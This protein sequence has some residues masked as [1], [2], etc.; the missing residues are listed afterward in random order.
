MFDPLLALATTLIAYASSYTALDL[1]ASHPR[2][3]FP[4]LLWLPAALLLAMG[5]L[6]AHFGILVALGFSVTDVSVVPLL[7]TGLVAL[8]GAAI[9]LAATTKPSLRSALVGGIWFG[10]LSVLMHYAHRLGVPIPAV[11]TRRL[12]LWALLSWLLSASGLFLAASALRAR[13]IRRSVRIGFAAAALAAS[14]VGVV[15]VEAM[16][17]PL[18]AMGGQPAV[19]SQNVLDQL[20]Q[21]IAFC[22]AVLLFTAALAERLQGRFAAR[23]ALTMVQHA[24]ELVF[25]V[26]ADG[27]I[28]QSSPSVEE[29]LGHSAEA[30]RGKLLRT[31]LPPGEEDALPAHPRGAREPSLPFQYRGEMLHRDGSVHCVEGVGIDLLRDPDVGGVVLNLVDVTAQR[32]AETEMRHLSRQ[33]ELILDHA[34]EGIVGVGADGRITF[35]NRAALAMAGID[36]AEA[37]GEMFPAAFR[38]AHGNGV[39]YSEEECPLPQVL[40]L[41]GVRRGADCLLLARHGQRTPIDYT[42]TAKS[43]GERIVGAVV[44]FADVGHRIRYELEKQQVAER[45]LAMLD[46]V[47]DAVVVE[48]LEGQVLYINRSGREMLGI[49]AGERRDVLQSLYGTVRLLD[50]KGDP[51]RPEEHVVERVKRTGKPEAKVERICEM[52]SGERRYFTLDAGPTHDAAGT[53]NGVIFTLRDVTER[54]RAEEELLRVRRIESV[55]LLAGGIAH[56]FNNIL[57]AML[58]NLSLAR[59]EAAQGSEAV[60]L[61]DQAENACH[62]ATRLT[63]QLLTF[64]KGGAPITQPLELSGLVEEAVRFLLSG[65]N[66]AARF[67]LP[68]QTWPVEADEGQITQVLHNLVINAQQAMPEGGTIVVSTQN[69][70]VAPRHGLP[71]AQGDYV[72]ISILDEGTGIAPELLDRIFDPY[73]STKPT[74]QGLGLATTWSIVRRHHGHISVES[75]PSGGTAFHV[76]LP[77]AVRA[78]ASPPSHSTLPGR[79]GAIL[80]MDDDPAVRRVLERMLRS[81]GHRVDAVDE[82]GQ[83]ID[84]CREAVG[85]GEAYDLAILDLTISGGMG[86]TE[87]GRMLREIDPRMRLVASSG[88]SSDAILSDRSMHR[89]DGVLAKPYSIEDLAKVVD[90]MLDAPAAQAAKG[91]AVR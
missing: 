28:L 17:V 30:L 79:T 61:L 34:G 50:A 37:L 6:G 10:L 40:Q 72:R 60:A 91:S 26:G 31:L 66:V 42:V 89:F 18:Q 24:P 82:G 25:V 23:R 8:G 51:L 20:A 36:E 13:A 38:I 87:A 52:P 14:F 29:R 69:R 12:A 55:G 76:Y 41:G 33:R 1:W 83:A 54:R 11:P 46:Q 3:Q 43:E 56:D 57:A 67:D 39:V 47:G 63:R 59:A 5:M 27:T 86:G 4:T 88:Y 77:R 74:G 22:I 15:F 2:P 44:L 90:A 32:A 73:F 70:R 49:G 9:V 64:S 45:F 53:V 78:A 68:P 35:A 84:R 85:R 62:Q 65:S 80:V 19:V 21:G 71:L 81:L 7:A 75:P 16:V 58:G 48:D